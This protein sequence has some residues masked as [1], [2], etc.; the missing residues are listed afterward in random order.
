MRYQSSSAE[1]LG[2]PETSEKE[3]GCITG[4]SSQS[5]SP[6]LSK[7]RSSSHSKSF[8]PFD[9]RHNRN[10][11]RRNRP[12]NNF[13]R[14][15]FDQGSFKN[16]FYRNNRQQ[17][18]RPFQHYNDSHR[19][20]RKH[21]VIEQNKIDSNKRE[22]YILKPDNEYN[23]RNSNSNVPKISEIKESAK[24]SNQSFLAM[25]EEKQKLSAFVNNTI[26]QPPT[27]K[28]IPVR[29]HTFVNTF[30]SINNNESKIVDESSPNIN[31][32]VVEKEAMKNE[33]NTS[34]KKQKRSSSCSEEESDSSTYGP[35]KKKSSTDLLNASINS[36]R[37]EGEIKSDGEKKG[38]N[39][40]S[41]KQKSSCSSSDE[42]SKKRKSKKSKKL[43]KKKKKRRYSSSS[44]SSS[45]SYSSNSSS[46]DSSSGSYD[47]ESSDSSSSSDSDSS[48]H[49]KGSN[50][51]RKNK[52]INKKKSKRK[53]AKLKKKSKKAEKASKPKAVD[54]DSNVESEQR[55]VEWP[56]EL[57]TYTETKPSIEFCI[58]PDYAE[59]FIDYINA[60]CEPL[61]SPNLD[62]GKY[63]KQSDL[64]KNKNFQEMIKQIQQKNI[65]THS[66]NSN[67]MKSKL[68]FVGKLK[69]L[70]KSKTRTSLAPIKTDLNHDYNYYYQYYYDDCLP[71]L[72]SNEQAQSSAYFRA[73]FQMMNSYDYTEEALAAWTKQR[74]Y[75]L[76]DTSKYVK[77]EQF[78]TD[79]NVKIKNEPHVTIVVF[80]F[81][82]R[83]DFQIDFFRMKLIHPQTRKTSPML[84]RKSL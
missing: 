27:L 17:H 79:S 77:A 8:V 20:D 11:F 23:Q 28:K 80:C 76:T 61:L 2:R 70:N 38:K 74:G 41:K 26:V 21:L 60:K 71:Y 12:F 25:L 36:S 57:I 16:R 18:H 68:P 58:N 14:D 81:D 44:S 51:K 63:V 48:S 6:S 53:E 65:E 82:C 34:K 54:Y 30:N 75:N 37:E 72:E 83:N 1:S 69:G 29:I 10:D 47:S 43:K 59:D 5:R 42:K 46:S 78:N 31:Q 56:S 32:N 9:S 62:N 52:K 13:R 40:K 84:M 67:E 22:Q 24:Q 39:R 55:Y 64:S 19:R 15:R 35:K 50:K 4:S 3:E 7:S 66:D 49:K 73:Y 33:S 45:S